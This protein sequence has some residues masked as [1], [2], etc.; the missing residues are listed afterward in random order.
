MEPVDAEV[1]GTVVEEPPA[2]AEVVEPTSGD[3]LEDMIEVVL[4]GD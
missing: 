3:P 1:T 4:T 2:T